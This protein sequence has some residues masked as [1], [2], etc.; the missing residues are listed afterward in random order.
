MMFGTFI[1]QKGLFFDTTHFPK[2]CNDFPIRGKGCYL[3][4]GKV[5]EEFGFYS[6][7]VISLKLLEN[8]PRENSD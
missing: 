2:V 3:I 1:D 7:D 8:Y 6:I 5:A 4:K